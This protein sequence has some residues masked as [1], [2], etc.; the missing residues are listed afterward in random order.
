MK[1]RTV[2]ELASL[3]RLREKQATLRS[4]ELFSYGEELRSVM[5]TPA[6]TCLPGETLRVAAARMAERGVSSVVV[7][8]D[9]KPLGILT[10]RDILRRVGS[11]DAADLDTPVSE[12][13][14]A[15]P[16]T[17]HPGDTVYRAL[18]LLSSLGIKHLPLVEDSR[19]VGIVTLRQLLKLR[20]PEPMTLIEGIAAATDV[21]ALR[22]IKLRMPR[23]AARNLS[24]GKRAYDVV[25]MLSLVNQDLQ[26]RAFELAI[27]ASGEPIGRHCLFVTGSHGRLENLLLTDQDHG[28]VYED[29]GGDGAEADAYWERVARTFSTWLE[30]IGFPLCPG[31]VMAVNPVWRKSESAW[32][33][34]LDDWFS[35]QGPRVG[36]YLTVFYDSIAVLGDQQLFRPLVDQA[37]DLLSRHREVLLILNEEAGSHRT[38]T[39][40]LGRILTERSG[41][42]RGEVDI[43]RSGLIFVV[44][45]VR[46]LA[47]MHGRRETST[48]KRI[49]GLVDRGLL[50]ADDGEYFEGGYRFLLRFALEAQV[51][52]YLEEEKLDSYIDPK[53]LSAR[54]REMLRH[55]YKTVNLLQDHVASEFGELAI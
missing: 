27:E 18:F 49:A 11:A 55:A 42:H 46:L 24:M 17:A 26:R 30:E 1:K 3:R 37:F 54:D 51:R 4:V 47:L 52:K 23:L 6:V 48:L 16:I 13:M 41:E 38:P 33:R 50:N 21:G 43:K 9:Q 22:Q 40:L 2:D 34:Q 36:R 44:E 25:V 32:K 31:E 12:T 35:Q 45:G 8:E 15:D 14:T 7:C 10:E 5:V 29:S 20:Y 39:G 28:L 19:L 53:A